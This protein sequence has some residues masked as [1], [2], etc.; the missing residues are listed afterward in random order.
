MGTRKSATEMTDEEITR[1]V[2]AVK[3]LKQPD[4]TGV[5]KYDQLVALH[6]AVMNVRVTFVGGDFQDVNMAHWN[7]GF[8]PWHRQYLLSFEQMLQ[9]IDPLV[10][11]PYWNWEVGSDEIGRL[12][13]GGFI[14]STGPALGPADVT[15]GQFAPFSITNEL[16]EIWGSPLQRGGGAGASW[17]PDVGSADALADLRVGAPDFHPLWIFW[18]ILEAGWTG[19]LDASH[20]AGHVFIG[21]HMSGDFS[22]NDPIFWLHH[23]NVDRIWAN[24]QAKY[25]EAQNAAHPADWPPP[26]EA[27]PLNGIPA[28]YGHR[29]NDI[30]WPWVGAFAESF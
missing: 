23:A 15:D 18:Q 17:P 21:G 14:G 19:A 9:A 16:T 1:F 27:S 13:G 5:S 3:A 25:L 7:I 4:G 10:N 29:T 12:F 11:L 2:D 20:N 22:P 28:P 8:C 6:G 24:W 26:A 30:M